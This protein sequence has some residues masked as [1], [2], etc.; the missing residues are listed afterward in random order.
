MKNGDF[1]QIMSSKYLDM[2]AI[3]ARRSKGPF[4]LQ[5][6]VEVMKK[7]YSDF[8][9]KCPPF[10]LIE[11][12]NITYSRQMVIMY[13]TGDFKVTVMIADGRKELIQIGL[14]FKMS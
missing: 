9:R 4:F 10:G 11:A 14:A 6:V 2:C 13:P 12:N 8:F 1:E 3:L 7:G 5:M